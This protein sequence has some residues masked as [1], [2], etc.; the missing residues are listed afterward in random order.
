VE[1]DTKEQASRVEG[2]AS[3]LIY[4]A[5]PYTDNEMQVVVY[6]YNKTVAYVAAML[7]R[8]TFIYSPIV[9]AHN[10]ATAHTLPTDADWW[11][12]FNKTMIERC[13]E[14]WLLC[15]AGW[16]TSKGIRQETDFAHL[17]GKLV[18]LKAPL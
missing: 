8:D 18:L 13:D 7:S 3:K 6:R 10:I 1:P 4:L 2:G 9:Y 11:W 17:I 14:M 15:L 5:S 16:D 12:A